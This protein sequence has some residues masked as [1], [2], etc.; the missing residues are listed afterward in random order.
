MHLKT[1]T[2]D[3]LKNLLYIW[4]TKNIITTQEKK[5]KRAQKVDF[6]LS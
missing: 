4:K 1:D 3:Y 2:V 5:K 6:V